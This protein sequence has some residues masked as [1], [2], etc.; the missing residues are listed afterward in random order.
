MSTV[1]TNRLVSLPKMIPV[2]QIFEAPTIADIEKT[3]KMELN[4]EI[5]RKTIKPGS[6]VAVGV[7][8]RG[9]S[10][11]KKITAAVIKQLIEWGASPFIVPAMGSHGGGTGEGQKKVLAEFGITEESMGVPMVSTMDVVQIGTLDNGMP[12]YLDKEAY[13][14]DAIVFINRVKPHTSFKGDYESG[15]LKMIAIG[16]GRHKGALAV[17][18][19]PLAE[20]PILLPK[21]AEIYLKQAPIAFGVAVLENAYD[22]TAQIVAVPGDEMIS[23]DKDLLIKAKQYMPRIMPQNIDLLIVTEM[24]KNI[25]GSGMDPNI[26]GRAASKAP[27]K[28]NAPQIE[29]LAVLGLTKETKGNACGIGVADVTTKRVFDQVDLDYTY[30]NVITSKVLDSAKIPLVMRDDREA[31]SVALKTCYNINL[32]NP[33]VVWIKNTLELENIL[34]SESILRDIKGNPQIKVL[35]EPFEI[36]FDSDHYISTDIWRGR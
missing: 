21:I 31:I 1:E 2:R 30:A 22:Q 32:E 34:V 33:R 35:G 12:L 27:Q 20:M 14:S 36:T 11:I 26:T 10:N 5:F 16:L 7:G 15:L 24:G 28:F 9:I 25:S 17:H 19:H 6:R 8:S 4:K 23:K 18:Q 29:R 3:V 13:H